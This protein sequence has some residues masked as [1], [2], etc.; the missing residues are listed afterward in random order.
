MPRFFRLATDQHLTPA[1][2]DGVCAGP[3]PAACW[4]IGG[5]P[6]LARL[7]C[8]DIARSPA[9]KFAINLAGHRLM[10][11]NFW[12]AYDPSIRFHKSLYLDAGIVKFLPRSRAMDLVPE[13]NFKV[14]D[15]PQT[16]FFDR[17]PQRGYHDFLS[18]ETLGIVDWAD[19]LVQAIDIA[20]RL[21]FRKLYLAGCELLVRPSRELIA[22]AARVDVTYTDGEPLADFVRRCRAAGL[23]DHDL[24]ASQLERQYHFD[25]EK[26]F[27]SAVRTDTHYFRIVQ[28][29][30]LCRSAMATAGLQLISVTPRSRLND[31]FPYQPAEAVL[32]ELRQEIGDPACEPTRGLYTQTT[33]RSI[34]TAILKDVQPPH[35]KT[36]QR[37]S[38]C[39]CRQWKPVAVDSPSAELIVEEEAWQP[40]PGEGGFAAQFVM[41]REEA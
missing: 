29:L 36:A 1:A 25:E 18:S 19:S 26:P 27:E 23:N 35:R 20:Y 9:P 6:S 13:S 15:C 39:P 8:E 4:M 17:D 32:D 34:T 21:G 37:K 2:W 30:R 3:V 41:P 5:G 28:S 22:R 7:P 14:C 24:Q 11:P 33:D 40:V 16:Y 38:P 12:T 31:F 10:R